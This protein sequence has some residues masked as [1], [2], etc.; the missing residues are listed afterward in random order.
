M[1]DCW[2]CKAAG[3]QSETGRRCGDCLQA[4][5]CTQ[6]C[7]DQH[8]PEH[9]Q[10]C[11]GADIRLGRLRI[12]VGVLPSSDPFAT[13]YDRAMG[14]VLGKMCGDALGTRAVGVERDVLSSRPEL[15]EALMAGETEQPLPGA[16]WPTLLPGQISGAGESWI[17]TAQGVL[18]DPNRPVRSAARYLIE[19]ANQTQLPAFEI[20]EEL[21]ALIPRDLKPDASAPERR[22]QTAA[23][24]NTAAISSATLVRASVFALWGWRTG[25]QKDLEQHTLKN[26]QLTHANPDL[27]HATV[28]YALICRRLLTGELHQRGSEAITA[29]QQYM[30]NKSPRGQALAAMKRADENAQLNQ[31]DSDPRNTTQAFGASGDT[32][33]NVMSAVV[34]FLRQA[35][36]SVEPLW[37]VAVRNAVASA[38]PTNINAGIVGAVLGAYY[39]QGVLPLVVQGQ[40]LTYDTRSVGDKDHERPWWLRAQRVVHLAERLAREAS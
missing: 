27:L 22:M 12:S 34:Y 29:A 14:M 28:A 20:Q 19:W 31:F 4:V 36:R 26:A 24:S 30:E 17:A 40:V 9:K 5:Y 1:T 37:T 11:I 8:W 21:R 16:R 38:G 7:L 18:T 6:W 32:Y 10:T 3:V 23:H 39:G 2:H 15:L 33:I 13:I 25:S 35:E